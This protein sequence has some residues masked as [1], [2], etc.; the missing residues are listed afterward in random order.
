MISTIFHVEI[1]L[2]QTPLVGIEL[3]IYNKNKNRKELIWLMKNDK[4]KTIL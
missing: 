3:K 2:F 1:I 4:L